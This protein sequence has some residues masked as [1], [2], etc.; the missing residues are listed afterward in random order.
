M[1]KDYLIHLVSEV[2]N[3]MGPIY[4]N[5]TSQCLAANFYRQDVTM[6]Q[7][8]AVAFYRDVIAQLGKCKV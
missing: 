2:E 6:D 7:E 5:V 1:F 8:G 4:A 3:N